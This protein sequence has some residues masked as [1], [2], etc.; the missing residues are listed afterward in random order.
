MIG[1]IEDIMRKVHNP[2]LV[3]NRIDVDTDF[4]K[5]KQYVIDVINHYEENTETTNKEL[6]KLLFRLDKKYKFTR[7][8][9]KSNLIYVLRKMYYDN[10]ISTNKLIFFVERLRAKNMRSL[11]GII[12]VAIMT[13]PGTFS[14]EFD[15]YYCPNQS[16]MPR[17]YIKE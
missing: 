14:C 17:S 16:D 1:D 4:P 9:K 10:E 12:E 11:S 5:I 7:R 15:C 13:S 8:P 2:I 6:S 3:K